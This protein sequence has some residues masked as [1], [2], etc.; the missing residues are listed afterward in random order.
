[1]VYSS[2]FDVIVIGGSYAGLSSAMALGRSLKSVLII[3][4]SIS[5]NKQTPHSHNFLT[6]DGEKPGIIA[7]KAR[8]EV[9]NYPT[10]KFADDLAVSG[11]KT[12]KGFIITTQK[13]E[14]YQAKK[15]ILASG[16]KDIIPDIKGFADC[17]G[18]SV[19]H[20]PYCHGY[21]VRKQK[22]AILLKGNTGMH[23]ASLINNLTDD[24]TLLTMGKA[25]FSAEE[26]AKLAAHNIKTIATEVVEIEHQNG[27][28]TNVVFNDGS[29]AH[30]TALYSPVPFTQNADIP[31]ALGCE[32]TEQGHIKV[33]SF[34]ATSVAGIFA[35]GDN[36]SMMRSIAAA[37]YSGNIA[38]VMANKVLTEEQF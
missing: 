34:Q 15:L 12:G 18:I 20:C 6:Q 4:S 7:E 9:L 1:M 26:L 22:T 16:I 33:D 14:V 8:K 5:C 24:I 19:I 28:M 3:D 27:Q 35:C 36:S 23:L 10:V 38:G 21:E 37:V 32:L 29:K 25:D 13:G 2:N 31:S 17:W 11:E 30:F